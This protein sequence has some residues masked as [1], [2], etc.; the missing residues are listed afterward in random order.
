MAKRSKH[1]KVASRDVFS[2][3]IGQ[4]EPTGSRLFWLNREW[5][6]G[7]AL[8]LAIVLTYTPVW[9]AGFIW[10]D[11]GHVTRPD[12]RSAEG[13]AHIWFDPGATQQY[14]PLIHSIF[15]VEHRLWGDAP[16]GYHLVNVILF[17]CSALL[18][19]KILQRLE[20]PGAWLAVAIFALHPVQVESVAWV[21]ELKNMLSGVFYFGSMWTNLKFDRTRNLALYAAA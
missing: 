15:W 18:L 9:R 21:S 10:D 2:K 6:G 19:L 17:S 3:K 13:L 1:K 14:Y 4:T 20:V 8:V 5:L 12:L 16:L 7:I 11:D